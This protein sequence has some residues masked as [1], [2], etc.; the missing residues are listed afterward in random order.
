MVNSKPKIGHN[1][2]SFLDKEIKHIDITSKGN[3]IV[4]KPHVTEL[5]KL[6]CKLGR[7]LPF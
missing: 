4:L 1:K 2:K 3:Y 7:L 5:T 6:Y